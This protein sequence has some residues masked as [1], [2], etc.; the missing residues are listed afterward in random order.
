MKGTSPPVPPGATTG[1]KPA[2]HIELL[3]RLSYEYQY[4]LV[5]KDLT[6]IF[7]LHGLEE[8]TSMELQ[9]WY[10]V[11]VSFGPRLLGDMR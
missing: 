6:I 1:G 9:N 11:V 4:L 10:T 2:F 8:A 3:R 7:Q 5:L